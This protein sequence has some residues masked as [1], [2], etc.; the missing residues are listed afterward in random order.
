MKNTII[1]KTWADKTEASGEFLYSFSSVNL[2]S[3]RGQGLFTFC[4]LTIVNA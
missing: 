4:L 1:V 2:G 3:L